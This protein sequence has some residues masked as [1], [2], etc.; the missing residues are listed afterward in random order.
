MR[1]ANVCYRSWKVRPSE[2]EVFTKVFFLPLQEQIKQ[3]GR[4][5]WQQ[6]SWWQANDKPYWLILMFFV[7]LIKQYKE[8]F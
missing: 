4:I 6:S 8:M 1:L 7:G 3:Q 5:N 2:Q